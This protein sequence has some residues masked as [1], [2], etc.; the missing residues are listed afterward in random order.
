MSDQNREELKQRLLQQIRDEE[1]L[2][3]IYT[4]DLEVTRSR[5]RPRVWG[6]SES[7]SLASLIVESDDP[8]DDWLAALDALQSRD[9]SG[10]V[11]LDKRWHDDPHIFRM[12]PLIS[13][14]VLD[15][16]KPVGTMRIQGD[17]K[18]RSFFFRGYTN[19]SN[20]RVDFEMTLEVEFGTSARV[21][22]IDLLLSNYKDEEELQ[23]I[24]QVAKES[25]NVPLLFRQLVSWAK[26]HDRRHN[27]MALFLERSENLVK[28][29]TS[30]I[31]VQWSSDSYL[32]I[33]WRWQVSWATSGK[34][35]LEIRNCRVARE[36]QT[37]AAAVTRSN[38]LKNLM[39]CVGGDC[40]K[41]LDII[42]Q[43]VVVPTSS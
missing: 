18:Y 17:S 13:G 14:I 37:L 35:V 25:R 9:T 20:V 2:I 40:E 15:E 19:D 36:Q 21:S 43:V 10:T 30:V 33:C 41:A 3:R 31:R 11:T 5:Q 26:F 27:A 32:D 42:L 34:E 28:V 6:G 22:N 12:L 23:D 38:G 4:A 16:T 8:E 7:S 1:R 39:Q 29:K 24:I